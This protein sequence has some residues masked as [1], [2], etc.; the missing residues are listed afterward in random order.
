MHRELGG[1]WQHAVK[2]DPLVAAIGDGEPQTARRYWAKALNELA[3]FTDARAMELRARIQ[4]QL[5]SATR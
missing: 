3:P 2:L 1:S 5:G 4:E